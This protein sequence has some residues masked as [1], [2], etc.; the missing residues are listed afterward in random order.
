MSVKL[1]PASARK[2]AQGKS[3]QQKIKD[4]PVQLEVTSKEISTEA[5]QIEAIKND[6]ITEG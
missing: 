4:L 2:A 6:G 1:K 3:K 5:E